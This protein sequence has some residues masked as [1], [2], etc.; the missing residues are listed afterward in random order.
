LP[1]TS[2][3]LINSGGGDSLM[4]DAEAGAAA[5]VGGGRED[6][7]DAAGPPAAAVAAEA[8]PVPDGNQPRDTVFPRIGVFDFVLVLGFPGCAV[9]VLIR[10]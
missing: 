2:N 8:A 3:Q 6:A 4:A 1:R 7:M 10:A 5:A 9:F